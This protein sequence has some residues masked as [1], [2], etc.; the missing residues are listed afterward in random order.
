MSANFRSDSVALF[1][2]APPI[3]GPQISEYI[4]ELNFFCHA[5]DITALIT[6]RELDFQRFPVLDT[7][8]Q[9]TESHPEIST[10]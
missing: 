1:N 3:V 4:L 8:P 10:L 7:D 2:G 9:S 5:I 6:R